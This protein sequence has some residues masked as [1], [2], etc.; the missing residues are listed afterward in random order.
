MSP[1][2]TI[3]VSNYITHTLHPR[4]ANPDSSNFFVGCNTRQRGSSTSRATTSTNTWEWPNIDRWPFP[5][6]PAAVSK[7]WIPIQRQYTSQVTDSTCRN[8]LPSTKKGL[9]IRLDEIIARGNCL[10]FSH[11]P[12]WR[13]GSWPTR[14]LGQARP[15][16]N[17]LTTSSLMSWAWVDQLSSLGY[18]P[19]GFRGIPTG[20]FQFVVGALRKFVP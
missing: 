11:L 5:F 9:Q 10:T 4:N 1:L 6:S 2:N 8:W 12:W 3:A 13:Q 7:I 17:G 15:P 18:H 14:D 20:P 19:M 16:F